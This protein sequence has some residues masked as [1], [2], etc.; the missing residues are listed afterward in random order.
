MKNLF[1]T[2]IFSI[3]VIGLQAQNTVTV[4]TNEDKPVKIRLGQ[5]NIEII[6]G[7]ISVYSSQTN[8]RKPIVKRK[9]NGHWGGMELGFNNFHS[10]DYSLYSNPNN[11]F[12]DLYNA[13]SIEVN[14]NP[15]EYTITLVN[16]KL[17]LVSGL[18]FTSNNY[19]FDNDLTIKKDETGIIQPIP[20]DNLQ[21]SKLVT[22]YI[23]VPLLL[24]VHF[25]KRFFV[26]GGFI[27]G[28]NMGSRTKVKIDDHKSKERKS[29]NI[30]PYRGSI[31]FKA[32]FKNVYLY[33]NYSLTPLFKDG[34]G[35]ELF[36]YSIGIGFLNF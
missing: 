31:A 28:L 33:S 27:G 7:E 4:D 1:L 36:P 30:N 8:T 16:K 35:P 17:G 10:I 26:S 32:G 22:T 2:V 12:M 24:E 6:D 9:F 3:L 25:G 23:N 14:I 29:F 34:K 5:K 13:K 21:K 19:R 11:N 15:L 20:L 18:G